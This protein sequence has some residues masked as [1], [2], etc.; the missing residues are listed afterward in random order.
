M[1][2]M[3]SFLRRSGALVVAGA[4]L[5]GFAGAHAQVTESA[6]VSATL[7]NA[8]T[9]TENAP[10]DFGTLTLLLSGATETLALA[11]AAD[12]G[13]VTGT[14]SNSDTSTFLQVAAATPGDYS[15]DTGVPAFTN[16]TVTVVDSATLS[17]TGAAPGNGTLAWSAPTVNA[18]LGSATCT[19]TGP[20]SCAAQTDATGVFQFN[21]GGTI[22]AA[23][24]GTYQATG[25]VY[26]TTIDLVASFT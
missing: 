11:M 8:L 17:A 14:A 3:T 13:T 21:L 7:D 1:T 24:D 22:T 4:A 26:S 18:V 2:N 20:L 10:V 9:I 12:T 15:V 16:V 6:N 19:G 25:T 5:F 23:A